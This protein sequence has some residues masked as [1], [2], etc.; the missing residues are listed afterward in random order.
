MQV[1]TSCCYWRR[2]SESESESEKEKEKE[3]KVRYRSVPGLDSHMTV[4]RL[5][6]DPANQVSAVVD[7]TTPEYQAFAGVAFTPIRERNL[8]HRKHVVLRHA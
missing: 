6:S 3:K 1:G 2:E 8:G 5:T 7:D 4:G